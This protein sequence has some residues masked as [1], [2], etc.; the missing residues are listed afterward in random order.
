MS[1]PRQ[2]WTALALLAVLAVAVAVG[3]DAR[4][5]PRAAREGPPTT[6]PAQRRG[7]QAPRVQ[8]ERA[9]PPRSQ[10][11]SIQV[12]RL[13]HA[14]AEYVAN[15]LGQM[16]RVFGES[17]MAAPDER[18]NSLVVAT[19]SE[20]TGQQVRELIESLDV[21]TVDDA[22]AE[23]TVCIPLEHAFAREVIT[24]V[25]ELAPRHRLL[26]YVADGRSNTVWLAGPAPTVEKLTAMVREMDERAEAATARQ[27]SVRELRF[28]HLK[29]AVDP[30]VANTINETAETMDLDLEVICDPASGTL[31]AHATPSEAA[32]LEK[33]IAE[34]DVPPRRSAVPPRPAERDRGRRGQPEEP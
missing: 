34:L 15:V 3:Q 17:I 4:R 25:H 12:F 8:V 5:R 13:K 1:M 28:Y 21:P 9:R 29:H 27:A 11:P 10:P 7:E 18:T 19:E 32:T 2:R 26:R 20:R 6:Q 14:D 24:Y 31:I 16:Q 30:R 22:V 33:I 23:E